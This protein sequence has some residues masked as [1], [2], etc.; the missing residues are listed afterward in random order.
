MRIY[1]KK[2][3]LVGFSVM[4]F[5]LGV[6]QLQAQN[7]GYKYGATEEDSLKC[8]ENLSLYREDVKQSNFAKAYD[9]WK[10]VLENCPLSSEYIFI[11]GPIILEN[12]I[13]KEKD[14][15]KKQELIQE[16]FEV[17]NLRIKY[18]PAREGFVL[19][20]IGV[21]TMK[22]K[23]MEYKSAFE[24]ME[25]SIELEGKKSSPQVL[26]IY[27]QTAEIYKQR[28]KL[29][30]DVII[31]AYDKISEAL[32]EM[33]EDGI[34]KLEK[35]MHEIYSLQEK[36]DIGE[37]SQDDYIAT[38]EDRVKDS[39]R[40][41]NEL[42]QLRNVENNLNIRFSKHSTCDILKSI[43]SKKFETSKDIR[44][45]QQIVKLFGKDSVCVNS[46]LFISAV[47]ELYKLNPTAKVAYSMGNIKL[48]KK[49]YNEALSYFNQA[50]EM[51]EIDAEKIKC[52]LLMAEC[53]RH[54]NQFS[55]ARETAYKILKLNPN[56]G[57]A[58]IS[59]GNLYMSSPCSTEV[60]GAAYWAAADKF[61]KAKSIDP[62]RADDAQRALNIA[63]ARFPQ[64]EA[65]FNRG[66]NEGGTYRI[67]C[68]IG[69][70]T[71]IRPRPAR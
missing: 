15:I 70:T 5:S 37:I 50:L 8:L 13:V 11:D 20:R 7:L 68:W 33:L 60:P 43:Y 17:F 39:A 14:S 58:Y 49:E 22:Y 28:D 35:V 31:D 61:A 21:Y 25:K 46:D 4:A 29:P 52:Y 16:L 56:D 69:E 53:Y 57:R 26:D 71:T 42:Q 59:V 65:I 51:F 34:K 6:Q 18:Y 55:T 10:W 23:P 2:V 54:L 64:M 62:E 45:L 67:D 3:A 38:Y 32:D 1:F 27:F 12:L 48:S 19:G 9:N 24:N 40:A 63:T 66:L 30:V 47:E 44:T 36:L 41:A